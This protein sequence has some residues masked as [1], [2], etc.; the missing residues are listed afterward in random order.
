[1]QFYVILNPTAGRGRYKELLERMEV[2]FSAHPEHRFVRME[3]KQVGDASK[4]AKHIAELQQ[5]DTAII[6]CGGDGTVHEIANGLAGEQT[7]LIVLPFGTG[8]DFAKKLYGKQFTVEQVA[9][10][11]GLLDGTLHARRFPID[12]VRVNDRF[13]INIMSFGFDTMVEKLGKQIALRFPFLRKICYDL[14]VAI[15]LFLKKKYQLHFSLTLADQSLF[16]QKVD[17]TLAAICNASFYGGGFCPAPNA[18]LDDGIL[19]FCFADPMN[20]ASIVRMANAYRNG[21]LSGKK[22]HYG[23][24][25]CGQISTTD[26]SMLPINCDGEH[27]DTDTVTFEVCPK[28]LHLL[29]PDG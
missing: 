24:T 1:M 19:D 13:F 23:Q 25:I 7:P 6:S 22:I 4:F 16:E 20:A 26:G 5:Q 21:T 29:L 3:T 27:F 17:F 14:S 8:N 15:C 11:Y 10:S 12:L 18:K 2:A 28:F 9:A